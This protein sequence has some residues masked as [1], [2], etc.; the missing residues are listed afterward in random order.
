MGHSMAIK[1]VHLRFPEIVHRTAKMKAA[2]R[3]RTLSEYLAQLVMGDRKNRDIVAECLA[4]P[5]TKDDEELSP[6]SLKTIKEAMEE[7]SAG[8]WEDLQA[9]LG[10]KRKKRHARKD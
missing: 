3:G 9:E 10:G 5:I 6:E 8:T 4:M 2:A 7:P 1:S